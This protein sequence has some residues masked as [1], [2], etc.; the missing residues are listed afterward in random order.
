MPPELVREL[1][2]LRRR[3]YGLG[4]DIEADP[5]AVRRL[6]ELEEA[7]RPALTTTLAQHMR[8]EAPFVATGETAPGVAPEFPTPAGHPRAVP[9]RT[10]AV[11]IAAIVAL[12]WA[13]ST[14]LAPAGDVVLTASPT[15]LQERQ[16]LVDDVDLASI[17]MVGA[18]L[19][20]F[21]DFRELSVWSATDS[22]AVTCLLVRSEHEG[23]LEVGC[24]PAPLQ[25]SLDL[26]VGD[27]VR[28]ERV[29]DLPVGSVIRF[30]LR[31]AEVG[32]W[33]ADAP[34]G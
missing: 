22:S 21:R 24:T 31:G 34:T 19:Q 28:P 33:I 29:G 27:Q 10:T 11:S 5:T 18:Q 26:V 14:L 12:G 6:G 1:A 3:A 9:S 23:L 13:M 15:A 16:D 30:V 25:P 20:G 17:G 7:V 8:P 4:A 2:A 32:V